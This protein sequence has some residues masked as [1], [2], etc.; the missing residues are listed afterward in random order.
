MIGWRDADGVW[1][2][3]S[4]I[5]AKAPVQ[6]GDNSNPDAWVREWGK[7]QAPAGAVFAHVQIQKFGTTSGT[8]SY[9]FVHKPQWAV[10]HEHA[11]EPTPWGPGRTT[12]IT[13]TGIAT[14]E[15]SAE[16]IDTIS[17]SVAG[18]ALFGG[19]LKSDNFNGTIDANGN[20]T[21]IGTTGWAITVQGNIVMNNL[22]ARGWIQDG[23]VSDG[24]SYWRYNTTTN[25]ANET[26]ATITLGKEPTA[27][28]LFQISVSG[29]IKR[30]GYTT[31]QT[32]T[33]KDGNPVYSTTYS[34][35]ALRLQERRKVGGSWQGWSTLWTS[36]WDTDN[37]FTQYEHLDTRL[38]YDCEDMQ[39]RVL[40]LLSSYDYATFSQP[41]T[42]RV[43]F[44]V[45]AVR[46]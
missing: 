18:L 11:T 21:S 16:H 39:W 46:K 27:D 25:D 28:A 44:S 10:T 30:R 22:V 19:T 35:T 40:C 8:S 41:N 14:G 6:A 26:L 5:R 34:N 24:G 42:R 29:E 31:S 17:F 7:A 3:G 13:G 23:A 12:L 45:R 4:T 32:G 43:G 37:L 36:P 15:I 2:A 38:Y 1:V 9:V 20:F 33:D